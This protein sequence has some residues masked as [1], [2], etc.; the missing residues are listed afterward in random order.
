M[1]SAPRLL[2]GTPTLSF[3]ASLITLIDIIEKI[4]DNNQNNQ[5]GCFFCVSRFFSMSSSTICSNA[6]AIFPELDE[7]ELGRLLAV[8][9]GD[10]AFG[11][12][13]NTT[14]ASL[15]QFVHYRVAQIHLPHDVDRQGPLLGNSQYEVYTFM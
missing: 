12:R 4:M 6:T 9:L 14:H 3:Q 15:H 11:R 2:K 5:A 8:G 7:A 1:K 10:T 13:R